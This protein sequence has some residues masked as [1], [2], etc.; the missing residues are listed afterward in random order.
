LAFNLVNGIDVEETEER[1]QKFALENRDSIAANLARAQ[2]EERMFNYRLEQEKAD[3][4]V[5]RQMYLQQLE[6]EEL[7]RTSE[8]SSIINQLAT[9]NQAARDILA[10]RAITL[11]RSSMRRQQEESS[12]HSFRS[13]DSALQDHSWMDQAHDDDFMDVDGEEFSPLDDQY[14]PVDGF[15]LR[16][17][18]YDPISNSLQNVQVLISGGYSATFAHE[19]A[20]EAAFTGL[21]IA[22]LTGLSPN[23]EAAEPQ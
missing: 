2:R 1:I 4:E 19:R 8:K 22:P 14:G 3:K 17:D 6:K 16:T 12:S 5:Q 23:P 9:S 18:Y 7:A 13:H 15:T 21:T 10:Q 11:K 20:L